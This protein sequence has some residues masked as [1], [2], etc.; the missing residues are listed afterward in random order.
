[1]VT[2]E[3]CKLHNEEFNDLYLSPNIVLAI[4]SRIIV[5]AWH[6]ARMRE[7]GSVYRVVVGKP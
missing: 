5:W 1:V 7:R 2:A 4:K 6:V 3:W